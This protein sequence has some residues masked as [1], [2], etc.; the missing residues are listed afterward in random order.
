MSSRSSRIPRSTSTNENAV[1]S[2]ASK[3]SLPGKV[4]VKPAA[5]TAVPRSRIPSASSLLSKNASSASRLS[6]SSSAKTLRPTASQAQL[7]VR[8]EEE[9]APAYN[10]LVGIALQLPTSDDAVEEV[11]NAFHDEEAVEAGEELMQMPTPPNSQSPPRGGKGMERSQSGSK[12]AAGTSSRLPRTRSTSSTQLAPPAATKPRRSS[13]SPSAQLAD[14][15]A[16]IP[17][18]PSHAPHVLAARR[19]SSVSPLPPTSQTSSS[20][21]PQQLAKSSSRCSLSASTARAASPA[22]KAAPSAATKP[23]RRSSKLR[24]RPSETLPQPIT[25]DSSDDDGLDDPLLLYGPEQTR[26]K[27]E[28]KQ[29]T[30][31]SGMGRTRTVTPVPQKGVLRRR[32]EAKA[33]VGA[34]EREVKKEESVEGEEQETSQPVDDEEEMEPT[35]EEEEMDD[36]APVDQHGDPPDLEAADDA[37]FGGGFEDH[38]FQDD[39]AFAAAAEFDQPEEPADLSIYG[40]TD[41][42]APLHDPS[43]G[44]EADPE[45]L[46]EREHEERHS[47]SP[48]APPVVEEEQPAAFDQADAPSSD[49]T[50]VDYAPAPVAVPEPRG[51]PLA[52][53]PSYPPLDPDESGEWDDVVPVRLG[54]SPVRGGSMEAAEEVE[55]EEEE[56]VKVEQQ[57]NVE[58]DEVDKEAE[59]IEELVSEEPPTVEFAATVATEEAATAAAPSQPQAEAAL[60]VPPPS[61]GYRS[62][63]PA[64]LSPFFRRPAAAATFSPEPSSAPRRSTPSLSFASPRLPRDRYPSLALP[65]FPS[66]ATA[67]ITAR[68]PSVSAAS[69]QAPP[70][71]AVSATRSWTRGPAFF[72]SSSFSPPPHAEQPRSATL[73]T[74]HPGRDESEA[75]SEHGAAEQSREYHRFADLTP[76]S[77]HVE[78]IRELREEIRAM[79]READELER[80]DEQEEEEEEVVLVGEEQQALNRARSKSASPPRQDDLPSAALA[81][82]EED[83][84]DEED[85]APPTPAKDYDTRMSSPVASLRLGQSPPRSPNGDVLMSSP[86]PRAASPAAQQSPLR[87]SFAGSPSPPLSSPPSLEYKKLPATPSAAG[88][89]EADEDARMGSPSPAK[90]AAASASSARR[91]GG[92]VEVGKEKLQGLLFGPRASV[93]EG[94][95]AKQVETEPQGEE[96]DEA[97]EDDQPFP[98]FASRVKPS[99]PLPRASPSHADESAFSASHSH[100]NLS[101][102]ST[103][104]RFSTSSR[105]R[106]R[107]SRPSHPTLPVIEISSTDAKAAA[108]AA[109][110]LKCYHDYIEQGVEAVEAGEKSLRRIDG[111]LEQD[112]E[113]DEEELRTLLLDAEDEVRQSLPRRRRSGS[114]T[115]ASVDGTASIDTLPA[116]QPAPP[117]A[118]HDRQRTSSSRTTNSAST[119]SSVVNT[120][121]WTSS[122]WRRLEQTLVEVGR[123]HRRGT[124]VSSISAG[125]ESFVTNASAVGEEVDAEVVVDAFLRKWGVAREECEGQWAWDTLVTRVNALKTRRAKDVRLKRAS[126]VSSTS[127]SLYGRAPLPPPHSSQHKQRDRRE[128][129]ETELRR[130]SSPASPEEEDEQEQSRSEE[131]DERSPSP[132]P[133]VVK[134]EPASDSEED[135]PSGEVTSS[136]EEDHESRQLED[137]TFFGTTRSNKERRA[138]RTSV[139][140]VYLPTALANPA[141]RHLYEATPPEKPKVPVRDYLDDETPSSAGAGGDEVAEEDESGEEERARNAT[142]PE[143]EREPSQPPSSA[144]RLISYLGSFVRRSPAPEPSPSSTCVAPP[145]PAAG[146]PEGSLSPSPEEPEMREVQ[147]HASVVTPRF[148]STSKPFP[149]V[150]GA[151]KTLPHPGDRKIL[152][153]PPTHFPHSLSSGNLATPQPVAS[154]SKVTLDGPGVS[155]SAPQPYRRRRRSSGETGRVWEVVN[156]IEEAESSREEEEARI[157]ELLQS[158]GAKRRAAAGDLRQ[159]EEGTSGK[160]KGKAKEVEWRGFVEVEADLSRTMIPAG[161]RA[162]D[163]RPSGEMR[164]SRR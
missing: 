68:S 56:D 132:A 152:P 72:R 45:E 89:H 138:R 128:T 101:I 65:N 23:I 129:L 94:V 83:E 109:A 9:P 123:R 67:P 58:E 25:I 69:A 117:P 110:I 140:P 90:L 149:P 60:A 46:D 26:G 49:L 112:E 145:T 162:L 151:N 6:K 122:E 103:S 102:A 126:S 19:R 10:S 22:V 59:D 5:S 155:R 163:R 30:S 133:T 106:R 76:T 154:S 75:P 116:A 88:A 33:D 7:I 24:P 86:S 27:G 31:R 54:S 105:R 87:A 118:T 164:A 35:Q 41:G 143:N 135:Q 160:G 131:E 66:P 157:I 43:S 53:R 47:P 93:I 119:L 161:T 79:S 124:S 98:Q 91:I 61:T 37:D 137:D 125:G 141:L 52:A 44:S 159:R 114:A 4:T 48:A 85:R 73:F 108:R 146:S 148:A 80:E 104:S 136:D 18:G 77:P 97:D 113:D 92:I 64:I 158:G 20:S 95:E 16:A 29:G 130:A 1:P 57:E 78:S 70:S 107:S 13:R 50:Y 82:E 142:T 150:P 63:S 14:A 84:A 71:S 81:E 120:T 2:A 51:R 62:P 74:R 127:T 12:L 17:A 3:P 134:Q 147:L 38:Q 115:S 28:G 11:K 36:Q 156:A 32:S 40:Q 144:S 34:K 121:A 39:A 42:L 8:G 21:Q 96:E 153:L 15:A 100:S 99:S 139:Q 55:E 111:E